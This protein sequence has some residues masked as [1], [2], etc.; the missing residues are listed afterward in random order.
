MKI[1]AL[2]PIKNDRWILDT[3]IPQLKLFSDE[4]LCLD[5][6][7]TDD[8]KKILEQHGVI[9]KDQDQSNLNY[10]HWRQEL[11]DWGRER[12]GTHFVWLDS[13]EAFTTNFLPSFKQEIEKLKP[14][15][16]LSMQWLCLWKSPYVYREDTS[17]WS[18]LYKDFIFCD[19]GVSNFGDTKIHEGRTPGSN[20]PETIV[21]I[22]PEKGAVLHFQFVPFD[23]F[24]VKQAY[25]RCRELT[26][27]NNPKKINL[28]YSETL[29]TNKAK[30]REIP[31]SWTEGIHKLETIGSTAPGWFTDGIYD[32]FKAKGVQFF[33]PVQIWH[34][35]EFYDKFVSETGRKPK[36]KTYHP[37]LVWI[38]GIKNKIKNKLRK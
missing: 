7:S 26:L 19:D 37:L 31:K 24:Q 4:I 34:I 29:D 1:I 36:I 11:L 10:S 9:V 5:G 12:G 16:K 32:Y 23:R 17:V 8:T 13:D 30:C 6:G 22:P 15:Q 14:G 2:F 21:T 35:K 38:N 18:N 3:T 25:Q 33:E 20:T 27:G 28:R